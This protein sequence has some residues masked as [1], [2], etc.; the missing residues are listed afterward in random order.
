MTN[1]QHDLSE[2][3]IRASWHAPLYDVWHGRYGKEAADHVYV[4]FDADV[5]VYVG[6]TKRG[7]CRRL[8]AHFYQPFALGFL[9]RS[10]QPAFDGLE[11]EVIEI[12]KGTYLY[13][14]LRWPL[15]KAENHFIRVYKPRFNLTMNTRSRG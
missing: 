15:T 7:A 11:V 10:R 12:A 14:L 9:L 3:S 1:I 8:H 2:F 5:A 4:V 6:S 13:D